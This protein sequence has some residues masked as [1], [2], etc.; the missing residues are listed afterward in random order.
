MG[1]RSAMRYRRL[2][3]A[4][5]IIRRLICLLRR[6]KTNHKGH[7]GT[8]RGIGQE[9]VSEKCSDSQ[10]RMIALRTLVVVRAL[11]DFASRSFVSF[12]VKNLRSAVLVR[13]PEL[14]HKKADAGG[15]H[16][17]KDAEDDCDPVPGQ[18]VRVRRG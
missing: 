14:L 13:P 3:G 1:R 8:R 18:R 16:R 10:V 5:F 4:R 2:A 6:N 9:S 17:P 12:V 15:K 7:E 11:L